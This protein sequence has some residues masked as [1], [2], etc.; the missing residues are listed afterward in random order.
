MVDADAHA[1]AAVCDGAAQSKIWFTNWG[2]IKEELAR[3]GTGVREHRETPVRMNGGTV[4]TSSWP[5][6]YRGDGLAVY[7]WVILERTPCCSLYCR[8]RCPYS[9]PQPFPGTV[10]PP[11]VLRLDR[12][13]LCQSCVSDPPQLSLTPLQNGCQGSLPLPQC[14]D[15]IFGRA[16]RRERLSLLRLKSLRN[17]AVVWAASLK[18]NHDQQSTTESPYKYSLVSCASVC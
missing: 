13:T 7:R 10:A 5:Y 16:F 11:V 1:A 15:R 18:Y 12:E 4:C 3:Q 6:E 8:C 14:S 9:R 2:N 17:A